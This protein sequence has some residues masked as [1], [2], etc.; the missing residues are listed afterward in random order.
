LSENIIGKYDFLWP[1]KKQAGQ[2]DM[3][4]TL[5]VHISFLEKKLDDLHKEFLDD[6]RTRV[7]RNRIE[8][9]IRAAELALVYYKK[10]L[11][12]EQQITRNSS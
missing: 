10:A 1:V 2:E 9:D 3:D 7:E 4:Q 6:A 8:S 12:L 11:E 5:N